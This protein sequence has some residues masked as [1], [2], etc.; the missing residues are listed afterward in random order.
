MQKIL[1]SFVSK[2]FKMLETNHIDYAVL[3]NHE[4]LPEYNKSRDIDILIRKRDY[5]TI[6]DG[7]V[8][9]CIDENIYVVSYFESERLRTFICGIV[10][11][12]SVDLIQFDFFIHTSAYGHIILTAEEMLNSKE[13]ENGIYHVD[14][15]YQLLDKYLYIKYIG[16]KFPQKYEQIK[17]SLSTSSKTENIL[18]SFGISS[19][20]EIENM[21]TR[22]FRKKVNKRGVGSLKNILLFWTYYIINRIWFK[23]YSIGFTGPDGSGKTTV[24]NMLCEKYEAV[25]SKISVHH[26]RPTIFDNLGEVAYNAK[27]VKNVD[28]D[29]YKPHRGEKVGLINSLLRLF[30]YSFD[31]VI[32]YWIK[33]RKILERRELVIFDRYYTDIICDSRRSR[34]YLPTR[35]IYWFGR[36]FIPQLDYNIL[37]TASSETILAR[38]R[39]LDKE[40]IDGINAKIDYLADKKGYYKVIN[41]SAPQEV[42][43][44]IIKIVF[45]K[46]HKRNCIRMKL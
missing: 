15:V 13:K 42:V 45:D 2:V 23:G 35:F 32:G 18:Q 12:D 22:E 41:E 21:S 24:I 34:I 27:L 3:R 36:L 28:K 40:G 16:A 44:K 6:R 25:Y 38:K 37:L 17:K 26:F 8:R 19:F 20:A 29:F 14:K 5:A 4:G 11:E 33:I 46:Q 39:E 10:T 7:M 43:I 9:L 31:Y 1:P 30:Y